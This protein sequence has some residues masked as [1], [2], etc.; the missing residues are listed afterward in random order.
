MKRA[1]RWIPAVAWMGLIFWLSSGPLP[2]TGGIEIPDKVAHLGTW[3]VLGALLWW[4]CAPFGVWRGAAVA[5]IVAAL[6]G[7]ADE[8]HQR[9][10][11][12]R[13]ADTWDWLADVAG[14]GAALILITAI[15]VRR[16][17]IRGRD[18]GGR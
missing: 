13:S 3:A 16:A 17:S 5:F 10:V 12:G 9:F 1:I 4:A 15:V 18:R 2:P 14:S 8:F 7:A 11:G 6:Y